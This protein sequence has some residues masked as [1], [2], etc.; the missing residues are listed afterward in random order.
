MVYS[1]HIKFEE[2]CMFTPLKTA[3]FFVV[4]LGLALAGSLAIGNTAHAQEALSA[5]KIGFAPKCTN[6]EKTVMYWQVINEGQ[7]SGTI[8]WQNRDN[9]TVGSHVATPG[10][11]DMAITVTDGVN[12]TTDFMWPYGVSTSNSLSDAICAAPVEPSV[13][14]TDV[15]DVNNLSYAWD[16]TS[17]PGYASI[18]V[19]TKDGTPACG[20][21]TFY[22][23][24]YS[25]PAFYNGQPLD[26]QNGMFNNPTAYPQLRVNTDVATMMKG[27]E[28]TATLTVMLP[29]PCIATQ[30]DLYYG[31]EI[32]EVGANGHGTQN[33]T[34]EFIPS[35]GSCDD[36]GNGGETPVTPE[37]PTTPT[38][39]VTPTQPAGGN[40]STGEP[41]KPVL[42]AELP[43]TGASS[44]SALNILATL[45]AGMVTYGMLYAFLPRKSN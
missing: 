31:P 35:V 14:C 36:G 16:L 11:S 34:S 28:S 20:D 3:V 37:V 25:L 7:T 26:Y 12:N 19:M 30:L 5:P 44:N 27:G 29:H 9:N 10:I 17:T 8:Q 32:V 1:L 22:F 38:T 21:T 6:V 42:P 43:T 4:A 15:Q 18:T 23:S 45:L 24:S 39:P 33:I 40:G 2:T 41:V 13:P